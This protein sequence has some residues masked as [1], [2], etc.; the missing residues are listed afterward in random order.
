MGRKSVLLAVDDEPMNLIMTKRIFGIRYQVETAQSGYDALIAVK[1]IKPDVILLDLHMSGMNGL[2][3]FEKLHKLEECEN[4]PV[5]FLTADEDKD[6]EA[7]LFKEG[8]SDFIKKP[9]IPEIAIQRINRIVENRYMQESLKDEVYRK[10]E[11]LQISNGKVKNLVNQIMFAL[12]GAIDAKDP[13]TNGHSSRVAKY[14]KEIASR[15]GYDGQELEDVYAAG[16]LH[17]VGKIGVRD[18]IINKL[19]RLTEEEFREIKSHTVIGA[20]ILERI[21]E[22]PLLSIGAHWHHERYDGKGYPDGLSGT[23]IPEIARIVCVADCY[24]AMTSNRSYRDALPQK[25]VRGEIEKGLGSQFDPRIGK[26]MLDM[27]DEDPEYAMKEN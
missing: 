21:S 25:V 19:G 15:M 22:L 23:S 27:I 20:R 6:T 4:I 3:V 13:Y 9:M 16:L 17:D 2:E 8:A 14:A 11:A 1:K 10:T 5:V 7:K 24:D 18:V 12:S 26:I